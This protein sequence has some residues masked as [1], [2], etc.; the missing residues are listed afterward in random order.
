MWRSDASSP[1]RRVEDLAARVPG[2]G[3]TLVVVWV[4]TR[5]FM[6]S[7]WAGP[8]AYISGDVNYYYW[9]LTQTPSMATRLIEYPAPVAALLDVFRITDPQSG[10]MFLLTFGLGMAAV[11]AWFTAILWRQGARLSAWYWMVFGLLMGPLMW[12]RFDIVPGVLVAVALLVVRRRPTTSGVLLGIGAAIKLWPALL[13][14]PLLERG[15]PGR[16]RAAGLGVAG[17]LLALFSW[18]AVGWDRLISP[19]V[20]QGDRGL[21]VESVPASWAMFQRAFGDASRWTIELSTYNAFEISGPGVRASEIVSS[22]LMVLTLGLAALLLVL[23][24]RCGQPSALVLC[25]GAIAVIAA[26]MVAN[27]TLSPQYL[28]WLGAPMAVLLHHA[29]LDN[30]RQPS[31]ASRQRVAVLA[32]LTLALAPLTQLVF[33][34]YYGLLV[35]GDRGDATLTV[36]LLLRNVLLVVVAVL[37]SWWT[38]RALRR[39]PAQELRASSPRMT[40]AKARPLLVY[41]RGDVTAGALILGAALAG[42]VLANSPAAAWFFRLT[43]L[44]IGP[45]GVSILDLTVGEWVQDGLLALFFFLVGMELAQEL[46]VGN[47]RRPSQAAVPMIA[48]VGGVAVPAALFVTIVHAA[49]APTLAHGWAIPTATDVAFASAVLAIAGRG[50]PGGLRTFLLTLAIVD[51]LIGIVVIAVF[52]AGGLTWWALAGAL[53]S[54][55]AFGWLVR[56]PRVRLWALVL[57]GILTWALM[58]TSGVHATIAGAALGLCVPARPLGGESSSRASRADR[59]MRPGVN[60]VVL[61]LFA[62]V[63]AAVPVS[64]S[65]IVAQP[66]T[67]AVVTALVV[68]KPLGVL[69]TTWAVTRWT[70]LRLPDAVT[71]RGLVSIGLVCGVGFTVSMLIAGLSF[72]DPG[73]VGD[74]RTA[75]MVGSLAAALLG[76][77]C[78]WRD[79]RRLRR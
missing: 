73:L 66:L 37:A 15:R 11:D 36:V 28:Y 48:A 44:E 16:Q 13:L 25:A 50:L 38:I 22:V 30:L 14:A 35:Y 75:V 42:L 33:P 60:V 68:G 59:A 8:Y 61:P 26:V 12:F 1:M 65:G 5:V 21:Q 23:V 76:G 46:T 41:L 52:Y 63:A 72:D 74:A 55:A 31:G 62:L 24:R 45:A 51:D 43:A 53:L 54:V 10:T 2:S 6:L 9:A 3:W 47:L 78:L 57:I 34:A 29:G 67:W 27:K 79:A 58:H 56:R 70:R 40:S 20:W 64:W 32:L 19:L 39:H 18:A 17:G 71:F 69:A 49:G 7:Q 4:A 77:T